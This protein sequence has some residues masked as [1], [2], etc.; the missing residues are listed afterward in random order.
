MVK[1]QLQNGSENVY[2]VIIEDSVEYSVTFTNIGPITMYKYGRTAYLQLE[3]TPLYRIDSGTK[4]LTLPNELYPVSGF[5]VIAVD[6]SGNQYPIQFT[7]S[8]SV[9]ATKTIA[10]NTTIAILASYLT[11]S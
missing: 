7:S 6:T 10:A 9:F 11:A 5:R 8:G 3:K 1:V 4:I 2:P